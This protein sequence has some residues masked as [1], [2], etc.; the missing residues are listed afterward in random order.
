[1]ALYTPRRDQITPTFS[2][3]NLTDEEY[4]VPSDLF[5]GRVAPGEP[6]TIFGTIVYRY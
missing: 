3:K 6:L 4:F 5:R 2:I 1:M